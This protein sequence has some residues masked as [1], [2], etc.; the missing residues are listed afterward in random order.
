MWK[1]CY[2]SVFLVAMYTSEFKVFHDVFEFT[3][4]PVE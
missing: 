4:F 1:L 3:L 2:A